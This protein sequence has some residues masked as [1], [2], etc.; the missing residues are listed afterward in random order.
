[1][2]LVDWFD[3]LS[4]LHYQFSVLVVFVIVRALAIKVRP[5]IQLVLLEMLLLY[6]VTW[7]IKPGDPDCSSLSAVMETV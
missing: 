2:C 4:F 1:M 6:L 5:F 7:S 3:R